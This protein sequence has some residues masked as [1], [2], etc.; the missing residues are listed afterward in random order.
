MKKFYKINTDL[1]KIEDRQILKNKKNNKADKILVAKFINIGYYLIIPI[2]GAIFLG[3]LLDK[4]F[5]S[6][7]IFLLVFLFF[8]V[9]SSFYNLIKLIKETQK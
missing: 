5:S 1:E 7:P 6:K 9:L 8:G 2:L 4:L 3:N